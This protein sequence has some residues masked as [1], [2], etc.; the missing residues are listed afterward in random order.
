MKI[1]IV[2]D[3]EFVLKSLQR[4]IFT[5]DSGFSIDTASSVAEVKSMLTGKKYDCIL[6]DLNMPDENGLSLIKYLKDQSIEIPL[7]IMT[8]CPKAE[9][10]VECMK[11]GALGFISKPFSAQT[12]IDKVNELFTDKSTSWSRGYKI[13]DYSIKEL[14]SE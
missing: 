1:L 6:S 4:N 9:S 7:I 11:T 5:L 8:G 12:I 2:D 14:I 3:E 10:A 13:N